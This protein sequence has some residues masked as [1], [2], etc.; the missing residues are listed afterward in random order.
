MGTFIQH[1]F[2]RLATE[3]G[4]VG[5]EFSSSSNEGALLVLPEGADQHD[6][7]N[8]LLFEREALRSGKAWYEFAVTK[9]GRTWISPDSLYLITGCHK[10]SSWSLAAFHQSSGTCNFNAQFTAGKI[11][12]GNIGAAYSWQMTSAIP[13]RI[14]PESYNKEVKNQTVFIRG[15][16]IAIRDG[17]FLRLL[18]GNVAVMYGQPNI[19]SHKANF[20]QRAKGWLGSMG[21]SCQTED[22]TNAAPGQLNLDCGAPHKVESSTAAEIVEIRQ[23]DRFSLA[24][25]ISLSQFP[26]TEKVPQ[27]SDC[28]LEKLS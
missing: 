18:R 27:A 9:L 10:T 17:T 8:L 2:C 15:F 28:S 22:A 12:N 5:I 20:S 1:S 23:E 4:G 21:K 25:D 24:S 11:I 26:P 3:Q 7:C 19:A 6:L 13:C 16:K 14:G